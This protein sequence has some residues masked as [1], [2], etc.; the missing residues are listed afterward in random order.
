MKGFQTLGKA[1]CP[2]TNGVSK[3]CFLEWSV[4]RVVKIRKLPRAAG[5]KMLENPGV[6]RQSLF[7]WKSL[8][9]SQAEI[10]NLKNTVWRLV[11]EP[12]Q[13]PLMVQ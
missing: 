2:V 5:T 6:F 1:A 7:F 12:S 3:R 9:L 13:V 4:Q 8:P 10:K 11:C